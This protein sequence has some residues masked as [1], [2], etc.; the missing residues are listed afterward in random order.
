MD[1]NLIKTKRGEISNSINTFSYCFSNDIK[2][3]FSIP[4]VAGVNHCRRK[5]KVV[6]T[7]KLK[8]CKL[9]IARMTTGF[10]LKIHSEST[11]NN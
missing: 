8:I 9:G 2:M 7:L 1:T 4:F 3:G 11:V 10:S 6:S 5:N